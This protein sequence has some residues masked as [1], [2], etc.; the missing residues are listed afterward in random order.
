MGGTSGMTAAQEAA[1]REEAHARAEANRLRIEKARQKQLE[2]RAREAAEQAA[3]AQQ[4][5]IEA[6]AKREQ[7]AQ[8]QLKVL[9]VRWEQADKHVEQLSDQLF[10]VEVAPI[11][12]SLA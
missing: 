3:R 6:E 9:K 7:E 5:R 4:A 11:R 1:K 8:E 10:A 12:C 2:E